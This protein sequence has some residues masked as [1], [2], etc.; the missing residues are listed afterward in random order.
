MGFVLFKIL[1]DL[2]NLKFSQN[3]LLNVLLVDM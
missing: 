3:G 2:I 1:S